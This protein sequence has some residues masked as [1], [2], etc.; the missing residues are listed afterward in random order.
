MSLPSHS[1]GSRWAET[2]PGW[3]LVNALLDECPLRCVGRQPS[4]DCEALTTH[5]VCTDAT[6]SQMR[7]HSAS[8]V[9]PRLPLGFR[10]GSGPLI[11]CFQLGKTRRVSQRIPKCVNYSS[12][13]QR[14]QN[15]KH[16]GRCP[17]WGLVSHPGD[18]TVPVSPRPSASSG[19]SKGCR[20]GEDRLPPGAW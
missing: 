7:T 20:A 2:A 12:V 9:E 5:P 13:W 16:Q 4:G 1:V 18:E 17:E 3:D 15:S 6:A 19:H 14:F 8:P 11:K 10:C